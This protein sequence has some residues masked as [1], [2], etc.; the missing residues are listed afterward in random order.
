[1]QVVHHAAVSADP[2][3]V[4]LKSN[5]ARTFIGGDGDSGVFRDVTNELFAV[6][7]RRAA[8]E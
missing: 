8:L 2:D 6:E 3:T 4:S 1:M 5:V 7:E